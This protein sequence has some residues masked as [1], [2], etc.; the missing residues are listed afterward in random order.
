MKVRTLAKQLCL[1][2]SILMISNN[3]VAFAEDQY[4][5]TESSA[6]T[7]V[8][9]NDTGS[10]SVIIPK[11][12][13][14]GVSNDSASANYSITV[15]GDIP[16]TEKVYVTPIDGID[17]TSAIDFYLKDVN[18]SVAK[19]DIVAVITQNKTSWSYD[20][21]KNGSTK[22]DNKVEV[23][24]ISAGAWEGTFNFSISLH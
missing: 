23:S 16:S 15:S 8:T 13:T 12:I 24:N 6:T 11:T 10:F 4:I 21:I 19:N 7:T 5:S 3:M 9:Y 22:S 20:E 2:C 1:A 18:T 17:T 14:L